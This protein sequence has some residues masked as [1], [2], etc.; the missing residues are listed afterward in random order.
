MIRIYDYSF[1]AIFK[2]FQSFSFIY[3]WG[4][5]EGASLRQVLWI[6]SICCVLTTSNR[7]LFLLN[8][9]K[10]SITLIIALIIIIVHVCLITIRRLIY[11]SSFLARVIWLVI[12]ILLPR[13]NYLL[14][15]TLLTKYIIMQVLLNVFINRH[16]ILLFKRLLTLI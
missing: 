8:T 11:A 16:I 4:S 15:L 10:V 5:R 14:S 9:L 7:S 12:D 1:I 2:S 3:C 6:E 13:L